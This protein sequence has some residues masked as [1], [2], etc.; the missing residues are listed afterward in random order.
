MLRIYESY[1][2][3]TSRIT[4]LRVVLRVYESYYE[5]TSR[6]TSR[7]TMKEETCFKITSGAGAVVDPRA[8]QR[9]RGSLRVVLL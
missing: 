8:V 9:E 4:N 3:F 5:F 1:Y 7:I 2:E 6:I